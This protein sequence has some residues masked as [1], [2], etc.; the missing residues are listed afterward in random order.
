[1]AEQILAR[2]DEDDHRH[3]RSQGARGHHR[4]SQTGAVTPAVCAR[5]MVKA[6]EDDHPSRGQHESAR[7]WAPCRSSRPASRARDN[8]ACP[9]SFGRMGSAASFASPCS[10]SPTASRSWSM[11]ASS[12]AEI[13]REF[14]PTPRCSGPRAGCNWMESGWDSRIG[15]IL[16]DLLQLRGVAASKS[17]ILL[18]SSIPSYSRYPE[19]LGEGGILA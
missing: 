10:R 4:G 14:A 16:T 15:E 2:H 13:P 17:L 18:I 6:R 12:P 9:R 1:G 5:W 3:S 8:R 19:R 7:Q 11:G